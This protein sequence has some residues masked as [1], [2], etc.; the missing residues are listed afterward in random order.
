MIYEL[1]ARWDSIWIMTVNVCLDKPI[2][3]LYLVV[4]TY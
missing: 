1:Q 2:L 3:K 4:L